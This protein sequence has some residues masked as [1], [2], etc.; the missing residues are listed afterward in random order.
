MSSQIL[1][2]PYGFCM[3]VSM[4]Y[5]LPWHAP[6]VRV[7]KCLSNFICLLILYFKEPR[8]LVRIEMIKSD[9]QYNRQI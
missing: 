9:K 8:S 5:S 7:T 6:R 1:N 2:G 4:D 3:S